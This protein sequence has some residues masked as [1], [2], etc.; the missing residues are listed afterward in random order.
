VE[1]SWIS[2]TRD[3]ESIIG[4]EEIVLW[5]KAALLILEIMTMRYHDRRIRESRILSDLPLTKIAA[6][7]GLTRTLYEHRIP[8]AVRNTRCAPKGARS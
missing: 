6:L 7:T 3:V 8:R 4:G 1:F 2:E 5:E